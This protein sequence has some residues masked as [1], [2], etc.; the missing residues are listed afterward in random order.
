MSQTITQVDR[1]QVKKLFTALGFANASKWKDVQLQ[2]EIQTLLERVADDDAVKE[3][4]DALDESSREMLNTIL[5]SVSEGGEV[6][7]TGENGKAR[8]TE[9]TAPKKKGKK[10][11]TMVENPNKMS[12]LDAVAKVLKGRKN[13]M[14]MAEIMEAITSKGLWTSP[15]GKTPGQTVKSAILLEI[16]RKGSESRFVKVDKGWYSHS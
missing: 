3:R 10:T 16:Q 5:V 11:K 4:R 15:G 8:K 13:P 2:A 12:A 1:K 6:E 7:L 14:N 9:V